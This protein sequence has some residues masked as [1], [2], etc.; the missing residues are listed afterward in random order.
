MESFTISTTKLSLFLIIF[1]SRNE[2]ILSLSISIETLNTFSFSALFIA[3]IRYG[4]ISQTFSL[5]S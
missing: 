3:R 2:I 4:F 5:K 1:S